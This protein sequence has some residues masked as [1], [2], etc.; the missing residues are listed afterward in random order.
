MI[1]V[2]RSSPV[3]L[4]DRDRASLVPLSLRALEVTQ[5]REAALNDKYIGAMLLFDNG[6][7]RKIE[8]IETLGLYGD[9]MG[10]KILS[11]LTSVFSIRVELSDAGTL[12]LAE[13]KNLIVE[14]I[15]M[16]ADLDEPAL[17]HTK[18]IDETSRNIEEASTYKSI[19]DV[20]EMPRDEDCL[21]AL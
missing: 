2:A 18:Q 5:D 16:D 17:P 15:R 19:F 8:G 10:R 12:P 21:D 11:L 9:S 14:L 4:V 3:L 20:I 6:T 13:F 7:V 1:V